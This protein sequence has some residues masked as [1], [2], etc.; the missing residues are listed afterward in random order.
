MCYVQVKMTIE[1]N[2]INGK[3]KKKLQYVNI[4][5]GEVSY[6]KLFILRNP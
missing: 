5:Q 2:I 6:R 3:K 4:L 1:F